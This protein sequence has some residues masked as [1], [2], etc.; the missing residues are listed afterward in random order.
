MAGIS[1]IIPVYNHSRELDS[2]LR[3]LFTQTYRDFE[4]IVVDDGSTDN[5]TQVLA[6]WI[7]KVTVIKK[8]HAG[9]PVARNTGAREASGEFL[10]F[11][12][13][14]VILRSDALEL[15]VRALQNNSRAAFAYSSFKF[16]FK[17]FLGQAWDSERLKKR[18]FAHTTS[19]LRRDAFPGF[20]EALAR[21]QDWDLWLTI[22]DR[23]G[24]GV[25]ISEVLFS[26]KPRRLGISKWLPKF[27]YQLPW[28]PAAVHQYEQAAAIVL[29][30]HNLC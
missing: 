15:F 20:D 29:K 27:L 14:D 3:A 5:I 9:A 24:R 17:T 6:S 19:L 30:K 26:V 23:G 1:V 12:D 21:F 11:L 13:A 8:E 16:G 18:N 28:K 7:G 10:L 2:A 4:V 22:A 25:F